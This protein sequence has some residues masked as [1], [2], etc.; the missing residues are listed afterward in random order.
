MFNAYAHLTIAQVDPVSQEG[1]PS[2]QEVREVAQ[3]QQHLPGITALYA[4]LPED[5]QFAQRTVEIVT[6]P[7]YESGKVV[8]QVRTVKGDSRSAIWVDANLLRVINR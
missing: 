6:W 2:T 3:A 1:A 7:Y 8:I 4:V 5:A